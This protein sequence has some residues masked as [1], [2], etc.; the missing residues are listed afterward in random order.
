MARFH[1]ALT[2]LKRRRCDVRSIPRARRIG[3][4]LI[5]DVAPLPE[6]ARIAATSE[7]V[8]TAGVEQVPC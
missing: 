5:A 4:L 8:R 1:A 7:D 2:S 6:L 3:G